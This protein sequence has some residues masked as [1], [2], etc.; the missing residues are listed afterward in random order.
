MNILAQ[1]TRPKNPTIAALHF[2][3]ERVKEKAGE[4]AQTIS[5]NDILGAAVDHHRR[6]MTLLHNSNTFRS[7]MTEARASLLEVDHFDDSSTDEEEEQQQQR[8]QPEG[9]EAGS[10]GIQLPGV[11]QQPP[12]PEQVISSPFDRPGAAAGAASIRRS[13]EE[14]DPMSVLKRMRSQTGP[15]SLSR[16][17]LEGVKVPTYS[18]QLTD[19]DSDKEDDGIFL[20]KELTTLR[21]R[22]FLARSDQQQAS[23]ADDMLAQI[24]GANWNADNNTTVVPR[25]GSRLQL[26]ASA[27][28]PSKPAA[29]APPST[30][31]TGGRSSTGTGIV[32]QPTWAPGP[33]LAIGNTKNSIA[34]ATGKR[35]GALPG[36][37]VDSSPLA[38]D[39]A[40][41]E[42]SPG[43]AAREVAPAAS[44]GGGLLARIKHMLKH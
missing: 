27:P 36:V 23:A 39:T 31:R 15:R 19:G 9:K 38:R 24:R 7:R 35:A 5:H 14:P 22:S 43:S 37:S 41:G 2:H 30:A 44:S 17:M 32:S 26:A 16:K 42:R 34:P 18:G 28:F 11:P 25:V 29:D 13:K 6:N 33:G 20:H 4:L 3:N 40:E 8:R 1:D 10:Q 12:T 21:G